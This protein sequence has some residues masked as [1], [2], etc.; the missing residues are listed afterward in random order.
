MLTDAEHPVE[1]DEMKIERIISALRKLECPLT[2]IGIEFWHSAI[3]QKPFQNSTQNDIL[4][5]SDANLHQDLEHK[6]KKNDEYDC[7][8]SN[9]EKLN[10]EELIKQ[11]NEKMLISFDEMDWWWSICSF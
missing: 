11:E 5:E 6:S 3:F 4:M 2:V 10:S 7:V 9:S 1:I 8:N